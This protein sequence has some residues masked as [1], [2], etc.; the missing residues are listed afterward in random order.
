MKVL[1]ANVN[2]SHY[3]LQ[4]QLKLITELGNGQEICGKCIT[5]I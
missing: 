3:N 1:F 2:N 4:S 5:K